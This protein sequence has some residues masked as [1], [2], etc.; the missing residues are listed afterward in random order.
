[1]REDELCALK[2]GGPCRAPVTR[3]LISGLELCAIV[4]TETAAYVAIDSR[5]LVA[6][7]NAGLPVVW[8]CPH[9]WWAARRLGP[10]GTVD[11][12]QPETAG[13]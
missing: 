8:S 6:A 3:T 12:W 13:G 11:S 4:G 5:A 7:T 1:M 10:S 2:S 9:A